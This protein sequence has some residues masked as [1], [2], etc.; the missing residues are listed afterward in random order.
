MGKN[1]GGTG[2]QPVRCSVCNHASRP[3]IDRGLLN[4]VPLR[5]L[6]ADYGLSPSALCRHTK[7][8]RRQLALEQRQADQSHLSAL[9]DRLDLLEVRLDRLFHKAEDF[10]SLHISLGCLQ[11]SIRLLSLREKVR[12]ALGS[13]P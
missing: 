8:L 9:L 3:E 2:F 6:A 5:T 1:P 4:G 12:H 10:H 11:E 7:H 13:R